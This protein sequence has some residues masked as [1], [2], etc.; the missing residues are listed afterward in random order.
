M[1]PSENFRY[2]KYLNQN[3]DI[4]KK[5]NAKE[6]SNCY[7]IVL[8]SHASK[9]M[10]KILQARLQQYVN[11]ENPNVQAGIRK[12]Q[13]S[14]KS[15]CQHLLGHRESKGVPKSIYF[16]LVDYAKVFDCVDHNKQQRML[17]EMEIPD[18]FTC[19]LRNL[20]A[21]QEATVRAGHGRVD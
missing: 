7:S 4:K 12:K 6:Y 15:N 3:I 11:Q 21:G 20:Y 17:K 13:S 16:C 8:I 1:H 18:H 5:G 2:Y 10:F 19:I 14:E 9:A